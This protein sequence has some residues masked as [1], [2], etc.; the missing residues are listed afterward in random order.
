V[1]QAAAE[2]GEVPVFGDDYPT[3]DGTCIRDYIH[4]LDLADAHLRAMDAMDKGVGG[5]FNLGNGAGFSVKEV[6][7]TVEDVTGLPIRTRVA[8]R[9]PGDPPSLIASSERAREMLGWSPSRGSLREII[10]SAWKWYQENPGGYRTRTT[11]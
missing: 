2:G 7:R 5:I 1:L 11:S 9:R 4:I 3:P 10:D 8:P 6:I